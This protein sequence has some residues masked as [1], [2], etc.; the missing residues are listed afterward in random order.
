MDTV[1]QG[2]A[3]ASLEALPPLFRE[4]L[5]DSIIE[6]ERPES[7]LFIGSE[8]VLGRRL[9]AT[10]LIGLDTCLL[11]I[12]ESEAALADVRWGARTLAVPYYNITAV[13]LG[14][15]LLGGQLRLR[16]FGLR[17]GAPKL[18]LSIYQPHTGELRIPYSSLDRGLVRDFFRYLRSKIHCPAGTM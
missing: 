18:T 2:R 14:H 1:D 4:A 3:A 5:E 7:V 13:E 15:V 9:P 12:T 8:R 17:S 10:A 11:K 6:G 16:L